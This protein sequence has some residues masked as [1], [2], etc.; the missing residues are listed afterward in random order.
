MFR[1]EITIVVVGDD[2]VALSAAYPTPPPH[3]SG[4]P[5]GA[6]LLNALNTANLSTNSLV[7]RIFN[8]LVADGYI[9]GTVSGTPD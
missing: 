1:K 8:R 3:G 5:S 2:G 9:S 4:Q 6:T 7:K